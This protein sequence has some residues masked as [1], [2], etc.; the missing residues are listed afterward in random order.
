MSAS[1][2]LYF[3]ILH[4]IIVRVRKASVS[5]MKMT[6]VSCQ[7]CIISR[8]KIRGDDLINNVGA[9]IPNVLHFKAGE[10]LP[11]AYA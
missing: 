8:R 3:L 6:N 1:V 11:S 10:R 2:C 4:N 9:R 5:N 7:C